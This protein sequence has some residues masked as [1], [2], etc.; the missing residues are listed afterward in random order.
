MDWGGPDPGNRQFTITLVD[1]VYRI[2]P[3]L[4]YHVHHHET[5]VID[6]C[7]YLD[8]ILDTYKIDRKSRWKISSS[9]NNISNF[10]LSSISYTPPRLSNSLNGHQFDIDTSPRLEVRSSSLRYG[11]EK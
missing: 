11:W 6:D 3:Y 2:L 5:V 8:K 9:D 10:T 7:K 1:V 4:L